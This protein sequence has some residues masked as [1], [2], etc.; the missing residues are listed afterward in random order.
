MT[1]MLDRYL[2]DENIKNWLEE[3]K[4]VIYKRV[5]WD[6]LKH[7]IRQLTINYSKNKLVVG[8]PRSKIWK[9]YYRTVPKIAKMTR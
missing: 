1:V 5:L 6:L 7:K 8:E 3:F 2:F 9:K 4:E